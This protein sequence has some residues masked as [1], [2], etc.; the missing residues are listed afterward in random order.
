[1]RSIQFDIHEE[2]ISALVK[3]NILA[4]AERTDAD[5]GARALGYSSMR[6]WRNRRQASRANNLPVVV[7]HEGRG[8]K[9]L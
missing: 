4:E 5:A 9:P 1:M 8:R 2:E 3:R 7:Q 6:Q